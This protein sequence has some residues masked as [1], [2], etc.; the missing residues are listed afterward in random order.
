MGGGDKG[1][2]AVRPRK[3]NVAGL[4]TDKQGAYLRV[5]VCP[6]ESAWTP[7]VT[8]PCRPTVNGGAVG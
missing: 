6:Q 2:L 5:D 4:I 3:D 1:T 8:A 7:G